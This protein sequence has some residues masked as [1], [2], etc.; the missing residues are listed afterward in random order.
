[1]ARIQA[2]GKSGDSNQ[3]GA[4][5]LEKNSDQLEV[6]SAAWKLEQERLQRT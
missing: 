4:T 6:C 1:M 2:G 3:V 5:R